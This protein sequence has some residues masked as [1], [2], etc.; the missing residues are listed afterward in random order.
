MLTQAEND[1]LTKV[2]P[3]TP[4]GELL[5]RY[6]HP[7][8]ASVELDKEPVQPVKLLGEDLVLFRDEQG[9]MGLI[10]H[11]CAHRGISMA[12]G[13]PQ[14]NGLR[15]A[16]HGWTFDTN[17][18]CVDMPF[19]AA[20]LPLK[21]AAY[22]VQELGGLI[23]AYLGPE[24]A[25]LLPRWDFLVR[26]DLNKGIRITPLPCNWLQCMDNSLDPI[27]FEHLHGH[28]G[29]YVMKRMGREPMLNPKPHLKID[30]DVW[31]YGI[32]KRR[33][34]EGAAENCSDWTTG[35]PILFPNTLAQGGPDQ[36][37]CQIR[38]PMDDTNTLHFAI[39]GERP[40]AGEQLS[41]DVPVR[42]EPLRYDGLARV[43]ADTIVPQDEAAWVGQGAITDR[44]T[45]HLVTSD[46]GILLYRKLLL[47][48]IDKV[49]R[50]EEPMAVIRDPEINEPY[51]PI[52]RGSTY[53]EFRKG[54]KD[55][56]YGGVR[57]SFVAMP[58]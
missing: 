32:Y 51:I 31:E 49:E 56:D 54:V 13:I 42:R 26:T 20:T 48:N 23:F 44:T 36:I 34:V 43:I 8:A 14:E 6:W 4:M 45:E 10:G 7:I 39:L 30:F 18:R 16:Y 41:S 47:E 5:R 28:Y 50:G 29:N 52:A 33:L 27:H 19:E 35:H 3:G 24:P 25:P 22:P 1:R 17:G 53:T 21:L 2:G 58:A 11:R 46:K 55:E 40:K 38:V 12:Y 9:R 15:C 37:S 57:E